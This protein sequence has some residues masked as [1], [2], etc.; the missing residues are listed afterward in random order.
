MEGT[1]NERVA[2]LLASYVIGFVTAYI[3]F[4]VVQLSNTVELVTIASQNTASAIMAERQ[5]NR[6]SATFIAMDKEGLVVIKDNKRTL[7]SA[8]IDAQDNT[9]LDEGAHVA[10]TDYSLSPDKKSVYFCELPATD[11]DSCR[12]YIYSITDD[13]VYPVTV[14]G[15]PV[16]FDATKQSVSWSE[17]GE[18]IIN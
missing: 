10:I 16:A 2:I 4:G 8:T 5:A 9:F 1:R 3:A 12:P 11:V 15:E 7:L 14:D 17:V 18:L 13:V 6:N